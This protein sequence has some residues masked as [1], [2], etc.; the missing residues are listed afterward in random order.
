MGFLDNK[1]AVVTGAGKGLG[2][3]YAR[4]MA[5]EGARVI[6]ND[7]DAEAA[8]QVAAD[9]NA[10][11][12]AALANTL[13]IS[14]FANSGGVIGQCVGEF[15]GIDVLV[16]N[17][18]IGF[19]KQVFESTEEDYDRIMDVHLRGT[20]NCSRHAVDHMI[21]AKQG[22]IVNVTS[23]A[24][25]GVKGRP[26]YAAAKGAI[27]SFTYTWAVELAPF[28]IRVNAIS[29]RARTPRTRLAFTSN[30]HTA[31][32]LPTPDDNAPVVVFLASDDAQYVTGQVV[33]VAAGVTLSI[34][35][36]PAPI[37]SIVRPEG[38]DPAKVGD[39]FERH[40]RPKLYPVGAESPQYL[41]YD[42]VGE[43]LDVGPT[44]MGR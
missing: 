27:A 24:Q 12:G 42:G 36:H 40:L 39:A 2:E 34:D 28:G 7:I 21:A 4:A 15:G 31:H 20:F 18:G 25:S 44:G 13:D 43:H 29:P 32:L 8:E 41:Y 35:L 11:G 26:F 17:A 16:N 5:R 3:A 23:G 22:C 14:D 19:V 37:F 6:V 30:E 10:E 33:H 9:I 38:W 1:R